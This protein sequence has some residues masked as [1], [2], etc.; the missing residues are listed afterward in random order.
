MKKYIDHALIAVVIILI[1]DCGIIGIK[2]INNEYD[3]TA[4]ISVL[5]I[6]YVIIMIYAFYNNI[7]K[8]KCPHCG[9][10]R[11]SNGRY[12]SY[13]GKKIDK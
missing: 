7:A 8:N 13:C 3:I 9:M 12:C 6:C 11:I 4:G 1:I 10:V 2:L 5:I